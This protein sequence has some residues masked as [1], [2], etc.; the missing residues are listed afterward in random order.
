MSDDLVITDH[1][2]RI[3]ELE[4]K[5]EKAVEALMQLVVEKV[6]HPKDPNGTFYT[7]EDA[8]VALFV[9]EEVSKDYLWDVL[10]EIL[11]EVS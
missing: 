2:D 1:A 6:Y 11:E 9:P 3:E 7:H 8:K 4:A 10:V 5:L